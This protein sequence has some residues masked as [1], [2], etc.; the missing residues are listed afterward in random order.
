MPSNLIEA[1][2]QGMLAY[3]QY[4]PQ[5][6]G[7]LWD[8]FR[9]ELHEFYVKPSQDEAWDVFHS[10]GRLT[11]KLTGI[12]LFWLAKPTVE[13][14]GRRFAESGCIRSARNCLGN[15]CQKDFNDESY[16]Q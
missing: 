8:A 14:H 9:S 1:Y 7:L 15:C 5:T 11:W 10:F 13:K 2:K 6:I 12:P 16:F 4:H 3:D